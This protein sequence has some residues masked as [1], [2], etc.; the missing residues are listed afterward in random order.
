MAIFQTP[1][2]TIIDRPADKRHTAGPRAAASITCIVL[3]ATVGGRESSLNWLTTNPSSNVSIHRLIDTNGDIYKVCDD[4]VIANHCGYSRMGNKTPN[5][6]A[7]GIEF[8]NLNDG[9]DPYEQAQLWSGVRQV[10]EWWGKYGFLPILTHAQIDTQS[11]TD[12]RAFPFTVFNQLLW[13]YL[14]SP[15]VR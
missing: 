5:P 6:N 7:L 3:H 11:K 10:A 2:L 1:P 4:L 15:G 9:K 12:P 14:N 8:V 13:D